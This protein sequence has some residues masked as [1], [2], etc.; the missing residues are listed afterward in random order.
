MTCSRRRE[1]QTT[2]ERPSYRGPGGCL[3]EPLGPRRGPGAWSARP[4]AVRGGAEHAEEAESS[5]LVDANSAWSSPAPSLSRRRERRSRTELNRA[6]RRREG[7]RAASGRGVG[8]PHP[9]QR[10]GHL[11]RTRCGG[12]PALPPSLSLSLVPRRPYSASAA[13]WP[14]PA[15]TT[16][17]PSPPTPP[18][19]TPTP[20][21]VVAT[22]LHCAEKEGYTV[23]SIVLSNNEKC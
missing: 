12:G 5:V 19:A 22:P 2:A 13:P 9:A 11:A 20:R 17:S 3:G 6:D 4:L 14:C 10:V 7:V 15:P 18:C 8:F 16:P 21:C 23:K 1:K